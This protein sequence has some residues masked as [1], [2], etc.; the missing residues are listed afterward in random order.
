IPTEIFEYFGLNPYLVDKEGN[1]LLD[2]TLPA[3]GTTAEIS[4]YHQ[5][6]FPDPVLYGHLT[7]T[8]NGQ[9][10]VLLYIMNDPESERFDVDVMPDGSPTTFGINQRNLDAEAAALKAGLMP[11]QLRRGLSL[12]SEATRSF[13]EFVESL[14]HNMYFLEPLYYHNAIIFERYGMKYQ[15][16]RNLMEHIQ[17][18]FS[19]DGDLLEKLDG[20][21][22]RTAEAA[23]SIRLR[24]WAIHDGILDE[25]FDRVTMYKTIGKHAGMDT[26]PNIPW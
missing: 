2:L 11:G 19:P 13:E 20:S 4:L 24:S 6:G 15:S 7:D 1:D 3:G 5:F 25:H 18:G 16:G 21:T 23:N 10:H 17:A 26:A 9:I 12:L 14:G 22:F 8:M